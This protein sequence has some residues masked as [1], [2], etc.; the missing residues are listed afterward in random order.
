MISHSDKAT[1]KTQIPVIEKSPKKTMTVFQSARPGGNTG[2]T[3]TQSIERVSQEVV[4]PEVS[5]GRGGDT[6]INVYCEH[7]LPSFSDGEL[8]TLVEVCEESIGK[9]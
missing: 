4:Y 8:Q 3:T 5:L 7:K 1:A 9:I 6:D 2:E